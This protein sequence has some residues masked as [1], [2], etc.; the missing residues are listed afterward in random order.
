MGRRLGV[1]GVKVGNDGFG[2]L[3]YVELASA[4]CYEYRPRTWSLCDYEIR[5]MEIISMNYSENSKSFS[6]E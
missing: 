3:N 6:K 2:C 4:N 5:F 1:G